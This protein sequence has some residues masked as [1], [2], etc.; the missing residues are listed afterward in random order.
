LGIQ[1]LPLFLDVDQ[2]AGRANFVG[3]AE[4]FDGRHQPVAVPRIDD[5][6]VPKRR[7][8]IDEPNHVR[9]GHLPRPNLRLRQGATRR[10]A[11]FFDHADIGVHRPRRCVILQHRQRLLDASLQIVRQL[12]VELISGIDHQCRM[13]IAPMRFQVR[14]HSR[15][16]AFHVESPQWNQ[17]RQ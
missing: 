12:G 4:D 11:G 9:L 13:D 6:Q 7:G 10:H 2:L 1:V 5:F 16:R 8:I 3:R 15:E 17:G 14:V